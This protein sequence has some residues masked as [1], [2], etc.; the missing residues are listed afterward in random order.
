MQWVYEKAKLRA[1]QFKIEGV[2][3]MLALGVT[4]NIIPAIA[5]TNALVAAVCTNEVFKILNGSNPTVNLR[6]VR[7]KTI[8]FT[9]EEPQWG[10]TPMQLPSRQ[11]AE[12]AQ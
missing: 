5:S 9:G 3:E 7:C 6:L 12:P 8:S 2:T 10:A 1:E 11:T 4:K